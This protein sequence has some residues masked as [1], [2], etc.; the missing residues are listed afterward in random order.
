M[1]I[2][3]YFYLMKEERRLANGWK[4]EPETFYEKNAAAVRLENKTASV[5]EGK[6]TVI[7]GRLIPHTS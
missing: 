5:V 2:F 3:A 6:K 4:Y 7:S 1:G